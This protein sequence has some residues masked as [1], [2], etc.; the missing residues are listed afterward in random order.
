MAD[1]INDVGRGRSP[2]YLGCY[3]AYGGC[4][5]LQFCVACNARHHYFVQIQ[6]AEEDIRA[7]EMSIRAVEV[8]VCRVLCMAVRLYTFLG[9]H[10]CADT[11]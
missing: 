8:F 4:S 5:V 7:V 3:D 11:Q 2:E 6:V 1:G 9:C 10:R